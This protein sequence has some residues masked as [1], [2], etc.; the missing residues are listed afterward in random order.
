MTIVSLD[1]DGDDDDYDESC[2]SLLAAVH[3]AMNGESNSNY[4]QTDYCYADDQGGSDATRWMCSIDYGYDAGSD[5]EMT[6]ITGFDAD[7]DDDFHDA[8]MKKYSMCQCSV[9]SCSDL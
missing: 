6:Q 4:C 1:Y 9:E 8:T 3:L 5:Y 7:L 2:K